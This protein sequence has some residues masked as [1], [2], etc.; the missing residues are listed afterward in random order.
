MGAKDWMLLYA[1]G[2]VRS[3]LK[4][5]APHNGEETRDFVARLYPDHRISNIGDGDLLNDANPPNHQVYASCRPGLTVICT[6]DAAIDRPSELDRRFVSQA[7]GRTLYLHS[8]HSVVDWFSYAIWDGDGVLRRSLSLSPDA[9]IVENIGNPLEFETPYWNGMKPV[10][11][12]SDG[13]SDDDSSYPL[14]FHPLE[15]AED[16]LRSLFGFNYEG[17]YYDDDPDLE[18][19]TLAGFNLSR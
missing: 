3:L 16:A 18:A 6:R 14:P 11:G 7:R 5:P 10:D 9:G 8:M 17:Y 1:D 2:Q 15:M 12:D 13:D 19:F 4:E